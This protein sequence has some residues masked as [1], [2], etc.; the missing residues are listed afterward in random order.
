MQ[1]M[2]APKC[3]IYLRKKKSNTT[4]ERTAFQRAGFFHLTHKNGLHGEW[5]EAEDSPALGKGLQKFPPWLQQLWAALCTPALDRV[6]LEVLCGGEGRVMSHRDPLVPWKKTLL[7][8]ESSRALTKKEVR[9]INDKREW[10]RIRSGDVRGDWCRKQ[11]W[12]E[13]W[14]LCCVCGWYRQDGFS[15]HARNSKT[16]NVLS[17]KHRKYQKCLATA[18]L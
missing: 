11:T 18:N 9:R 5:L 15:C 13:Q 4:R 6:G 10:E 1:L 16:E 14:V 17:R 2:E 12:V 7:A 3:C 8:P